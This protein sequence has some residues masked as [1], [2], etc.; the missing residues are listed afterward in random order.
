MRP[1][2]DVVMPTWN[3]APM[4]ARML[5]PLLRGLRPDRIIV[6]DRSSEDG[7]RELAQEHGATVLIDVTSLGSA[8]MGGGRPQH[9]RVD[10]V[11]R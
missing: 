2:I 3:S 10:R 5:E 7:T 11:H 6:V 9:G 1:T 8:R 4:L